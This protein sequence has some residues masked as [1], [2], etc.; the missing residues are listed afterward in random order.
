VFSFALDESQKLIEKLI[1]LREETI[2]SYATESKSAATTPGQEINATLAQ[3]SGAERRGEFSRAYE[4]AVYRLLSKDKIMPTMPADPT[5]RQCSDIDLLS[6]TIGHTLTIIRAAKSS[7]VTTRQRD[8]V[9]FTVN[10]LIKNT[11]EIRRRDGGYGK[12]FD[13][14]FAM[15]GYVI[16]LGCFIGAAFTGPAAPALIVLGSALINLSNAFLASH[17]SRKD[18]TLLKKQL[19]KLT[20]NALLVMDKLLQNR[21]RSSAHE[22][23]GEEERSSSPSGFWSDPSATPSQSSQQSHSSSST[24]NSTLPRKRAK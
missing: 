1:Q 13:L 24:N 8:R 23:K 21:G 16:A 2:P 22:S 11:R 5:L 18:N 7:S 9:A 4:V 20:T 12:D 3:L 6:N 14:L 17:S 15:T 10:H 19:D